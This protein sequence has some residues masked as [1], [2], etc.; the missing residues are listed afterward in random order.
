MQ[1]MPHNLVLS[2][3][4]AAC[5]GWAWFGFNAGSAVAAGGFADRTPL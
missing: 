5:S 3:I 4:G 2:V 1:M